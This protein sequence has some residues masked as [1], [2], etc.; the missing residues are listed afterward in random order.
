MRRTNLKGNGSGT[1]IFCPRI[2]SR[3]FRK[4]GVYEA[5]KNRSLA[6]FLS[7]GEIYTRGPYWNRKFHGEW[8]I[9]HPNGCKKQTGSYLNGL[10]EGDIPM[11]YPS[12]KLKNRGSYL[13]DMKTGFWTTYY[14]SGETMTIIP[15][16]EGKRHGE[17]RAYDEDGNLVENII[18]K[19]GEE[20]SIRLADSCVYYVPADNSCDS[21]TEPVTPT[22]ITGIYTCQEASPYSGLRKYIVE[23]DQVNEMENLYIISNFHNKGVNEFL[24]A[25][26]DGDTL[27]IATRPYPTSAW[28]GKAPL[29]KISDNQP[30]LRNR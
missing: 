17:A 5:G 26:L 20:D 9:Y 29:E 8:I 11:Y 18:Y 25:E 24:Y 10:A 16:L 12:G 7:N 2:R 19:N 23:V 1:L 27:R 15:F 21:T 30:L 4:K 13:N 6:N 22:D 14:E 3:P 28:K